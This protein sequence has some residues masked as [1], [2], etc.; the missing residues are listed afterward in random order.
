MIIVSAVLGGLGL[1]CILSKRTL[2]GLMIGVHLLILGAAI[3]FVVAGSYSGMH[4]QGHLFAIF[5]TLSGVAQLVVGF[6]LA[7]RLFYLRKR[8][9][10]DE[11]RTLKH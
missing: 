7:V 8:V 4:I 10:M 11:L 1:I 9:G 6:S 2:L 5:I 3:I